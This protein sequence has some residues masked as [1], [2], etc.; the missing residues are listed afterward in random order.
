MRVQLWLIVAL[1]DVPRKGEDFHLFFDWNG[2]VSL[3]MPI[4]EAKR[5][6]T[7]C[8]NGAQVCI[9]KTVRPREFQET[10]PDLLTFI[11][12]NRKSPKPV[13]FVKQFRFHINP[14][15]QTNLAVSTL[16]PTIVLHESIPKSRLHP[17][18]SCS[19]FITTRWAPDARSCRVHSIAPPAATRTLTK[20]D[21]SS[22]LPRR[23]GRSSLERA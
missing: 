13:F 19:Q 7:E 16:S 20:P 21:A 14:R 10:L 12:N 2:L 18:R 9:R 15:V 8:S 17:R 23:Y 22:Q 1:H 11:E 4:K 6:L 3:F 5:H